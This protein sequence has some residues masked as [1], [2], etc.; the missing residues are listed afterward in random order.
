MTRW[1]VLALC[2]LLAF[3]ALAKKPTKFLS[4]PQTAQ[5]AQTAQTVK[6]YTI[7]EA[8][9]LA[10][11]KPRPIMIDMYTDWCGWCKRLDADTFSNKGIAKYLNENF[12]SVKFNAEQKG[13]V[14]FL[15]KVYKNSGR[16]HDLA[17]ELSGGE[18]SYPMLVYLKADGTV[19]SPVPGYVDPKGLEPILHY[20]A[21]E[22]Y[23]KKV[24]FGEYSKKFKSQL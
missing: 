19:I 15:G 14:N 12:Y 4:K 17:M 5:T 22:L 8:M 24:D 23:E 1:I 10:A 18:L 20:I 16:A 11:K 2:S 3:T 6:W 7:E 9:A 21:E 13:N